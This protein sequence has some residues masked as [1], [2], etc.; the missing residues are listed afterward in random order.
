L[1][2]FLADGRVDLVR[3]DPSE[4]VSARSL[5]VVVHAE[6]ATQTRVRAVVEFVTKQFAGAREAFAG[7]VRRAR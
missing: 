1:P 6:L 3:V 2:C 4:V 5:W 7:K